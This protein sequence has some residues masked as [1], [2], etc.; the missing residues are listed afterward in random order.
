MSFSCGRRT[1]VK[2]DEKC[3]R[4][5]VTALEKYVVNAENVNSSSFYFKEKSRFLERR[6][7]EKKCAFIYIYKPILEYTS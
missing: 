1:V 3:A 7:T 5:N 2:S 4:I 6:E